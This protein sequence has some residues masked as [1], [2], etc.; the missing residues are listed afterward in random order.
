MTSK[1][2]S[3]SASSGIK[4]ICENRK[5]RFDYQIHETFEAGL[6]LTGSEVKSLRA[7]KAHLNAAYADIRGGEAFLL[8]SHIAPYEKGGYA[9]HEPDR[10]RKLLLHKEQIDTLMGKIQAKGMTLV[11][12]KLY[13][14]SSRV[15]IALGLG[16]GKKQHDKRATI[17]ERDQKRDL[18]R[19][20]RMKNR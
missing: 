16:T 10:K 15:K 9:N 5:A 3:K 14:K 11:P 17:K 4:I 7:G 2:S 12:M 6:V 20:I 19:A 13:F 1:K 8:Q 18:Q